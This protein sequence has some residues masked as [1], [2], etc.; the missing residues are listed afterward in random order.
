IECSRLN[1]TTEKGLDK[2]IF[3]RS[4]DAEGPVHAFDD[5]QEIR[6]GQLAMK[7]LPST[8]PSKD[9]SADVSSMIV[10]HLLAQDSVTVSSKDG[11]SAKADQLT[12][13]TKDKVRT[14]TLIGR[15]A[16]VEQSQQKTILTGPSVTFL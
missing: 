15:P 14:I 16:R 3:V 6:C 8:Q 13:E 9:S 10:E 2:K 4:I 1:L 12:M 7:L 11:S 5:Q